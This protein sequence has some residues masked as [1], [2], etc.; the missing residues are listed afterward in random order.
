M[1]SLIID[2]FHRAMTNQALTPHERAILKAV[3]GVIIGVLSSVV[4]ATYQNMMLH[5]TFNLSVPAVE[6]IVVAILLGI[7]KLWTA[8]SDTMIAP[9]L[10]AFS[11]QMTQQAIQDMTSPTLIEGTPHLPAVH[12]VI[13]TR[14][15]I[16]TSQ[17]VPVVPLMPASNGGTAAPMTGNAPMAMGNG[18]TVMSSRMTPKL[19]A[20]TPAS[21]WPVS[22]T[23]QEVSVPP[24]PPQPSHAPTQQPASA[25]GGANTPGE[26]QRAAFAAAQ[27]Q[28]T[29]LTPPQK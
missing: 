13:P 5:G 15:V 23:S 3:Q 6:A 19:P 9:L 4:T 22:P 10:D 2:V 17:H 24:F 27:T 16:A 20:V 8:Q 1:F 7:L 28:P 11:Q 29:I 25:L 14:Q 21:S 26:A 18:G 12:L